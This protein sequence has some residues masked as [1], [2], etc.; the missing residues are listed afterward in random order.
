MFFPPGS[1]RP[2]DILA[3]AVSEEA[4]QR[5]V[6]LIDDASGCL[7]IGDLAHLHHAAAVE[8]AGQFDQGHQAIFGLSA[9]GHCV[10]PGVPERIVTA[11]HPFSTDPLEFPM[12]VV[13]NTWDGE[14]DA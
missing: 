7:A 6:D 1:C 3:A 13:G 11:R 5:A 12:D 9:E 4:E 8:E 2:A 14:V 10:L